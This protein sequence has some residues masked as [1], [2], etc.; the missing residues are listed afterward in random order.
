MAYLVFLV[1]QCVLPL[2]PIG[3]PGKDARIFP[4]SGY[5]M[6]LGQLG[7]SPCGQKDFQGWGT[8]GAGSL[9][10]M[11]PLSL[12]HLLW[13]RTVSGSVGAISLRVGNTLSGDA[14]CIGCEDIGYPASV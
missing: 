3:A 9:L 8:V 11:P 5:S 1:P 4:K 2:V 12:S 13:G 7:E 10:Q 14:F 6:S